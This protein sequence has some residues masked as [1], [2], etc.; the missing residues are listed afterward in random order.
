MCEQFLNFMLFTILDNDD[1]DDDNEHF[2][3][4]RARF[5]KVIYI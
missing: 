2:Y 4:L 3:S 5:Y 1:D